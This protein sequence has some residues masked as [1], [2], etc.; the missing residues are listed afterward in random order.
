L[1]KVVEELDAEITDDEFNAAR[2]QLAALPDLGLAF[3][4]RAEAEIAAFGRPDPSMRLVIVRAAHIA[5]QSPNG[6]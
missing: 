5:N 3:Q 4:A 2:E 6:A 1:I